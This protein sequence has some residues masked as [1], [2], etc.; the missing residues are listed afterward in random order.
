MDGDAGWT[1]DARSGWL[2]GVR[3]VPSPNCDARPPGVDVELLVVH[4]ISLP[5]GKFGGGEIDRL[6]T[7]DL[8]GHPHAAC[9]EAATL[10]VSAHFLLDR[11]GTLTQYVPVHRRAWHSGVSSFRG[12]EN[13]ND[14][15]VGIELEGRDD[16]P[17]EP[18]QYRALGELI[19]LLV[20]HWP[21][22]SPD[23]I[24]GHCDIALGR[25]TDPGSIF[26][27]RH[28]FSLAF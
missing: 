14:F 8:A 17:Y 24:V 5:P 1:L 28:L 9:R 6:F 3:R 18:A 15:S 10:R 22:L 21:V 13:C 23:R 2:R 7:N 4:G 25:K 19:R 11:R 27:W 16:L 26:D 12:R 20:R